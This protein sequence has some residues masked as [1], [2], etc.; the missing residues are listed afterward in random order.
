MISYLAFKFSQYKHLIFKLIERNKVTMHKYTL[1]ISMLIVS[2]NVSAG[3]IIS[4]AESEKVLRDTLEKTPGCIVMDELAN[5]PISI[6][7]G[8]MS[9]KNAGSVMRAMADAGLLKFEKKQVKMNKQIVFGVNQKVKVNAHVYSMTDMGKK[10]FRDDAVQISKGRTEPKKGAGFCYAD[11]LEVTGIKQNRGALIDYYVYVPD[12][13]DW[14]NNE[15]VLRTGLI[16][17]KSS[18]KIRTFQLAGQPEPPPGMKVQA[19][20]RKQ[21]NGEFKLTHY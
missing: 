12:R 3:K 1:I 10:Y 20:F 15:K 13:A 8:S 14:A 11:K 21:K 2:A 9:T 5:L 16:A 6:D 7:P 4:P 18:M 19:K 17:D